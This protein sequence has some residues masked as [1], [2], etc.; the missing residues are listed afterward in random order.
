MR[1]YDSR[2]V[3]RVLYG[4]TEKDQKSTSNG[5]DNISSITFA[6]QSE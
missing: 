5:V 1:Q 2:N 4:D 3:H 6:L